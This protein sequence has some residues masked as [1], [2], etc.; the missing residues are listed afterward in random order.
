[1]GQWFAWQ[2]PDR[3]HTRNTNDRVAGNL[4]SHTA[5][6]E[7]CRLWL[8]RDAAALRSQTSKTFSRRSPAVLWLLGGGHAGDIPTIDHVD[9]DARQSLLLA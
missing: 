8:I 6:S 9:E 2:Q 3:V 1:M 7:I 4:L 5:C